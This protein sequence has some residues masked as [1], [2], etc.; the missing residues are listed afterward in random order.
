MQER[1]TKRGTPQ[2]WKQPLETV[3]GPLQKVDVD[4]DLR[5]Q[6]VTTDALLKNEANTQE[7]E[8]VNIGSNESCIR[9]D[10]AQDKMIFSEES[11][12]AMFEMGN[13]ELIE[14]KKTS[15]QC[16]S[17]LHL[18]VVK[19]IRPDKNVMNHITKAFEALKALCYRTSPIITRSSKCGQ[20][21]WQ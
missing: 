5:K 12:R 7:I 2:E 4:T 18:Y 8:S 15:I 19:N 10:L 1:G 17:C 6:E 3:G 16:P 14:L 11:S 9:E 21:P 20:N 13:V